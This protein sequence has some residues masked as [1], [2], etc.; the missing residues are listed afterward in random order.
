MNAPHRLLVPLTGAL[1][2]AAAF[3]QSPTKPPPWWGV[4]DENTVSL[5]WSF[6][7]P[8]PN[9]QDIGP[10]TTA[11]VPSWYSPTITRGLRTVNLVHL[12]SFQ[13]HVGVYA[14]QGTGAPLAAA[15]DL[16]VD[17]NAYPDWIKIFQVQYDAYDT[18]GSV[19]A[20]IQESPLFKR[21]IVSEKSEPLANGWNRITIDAQLIPQPDDEDVDWTFLTQALATVAID[22]LYVSSK[23]VKPM[24]DETGDAM[25]LV[26]NR[27]LLPGAVAGTDY[28]GFAFTEGPPPLYQRT[29]WAAR[30]SNQLG[31]Q[32]ALVRFT[33]SLPTLGVATV[34]GLGSLPVTAGQQGTGDLAIENVVTS[35]TATQIVWVVIDERSLAQ[36]NTVRLVGIDANSGVATNILLQ[37]PPTGAIASGQPFGLAFDPSGQLGAGTFWVSATTTANQ[38]VML[39]FSRAG[40]QIEAHAIEPDCSGLAYD[41]TLGNFYGFSHTSRPSPSGP[42]GA[43]GFELSGYDFETTGVRFCGDLT[44][45]TPIGADRGGAAVGLEVYRRRS[46]LT[47]RAPL[48]MSCL[49]TAGGQ[50]YAYELA[51]PFA[52]GWSRLGRCGMNDTGPFRGVPFV[53]S[54]IE[55]TLKGVP[56]S[57]FAMLWL[58]FSNQNS[59]LGPLPIDLGLALGWQESVL[60]ISPDV[61]TALFLPSAPGE[62]TFPIA[63]PNNPLLGYSPVF[64]QWLALDTS[65]TGFF[66]MSQA[67]KTVIYP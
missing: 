54:N 36:P 61:N 1:L 16:K 59:P 25:G 39:E 52:F 18:G 57:L 23:C 33:G 17:N 42:V 10:P 9:P 58:G 64:F 41:D 21:A 28:T 5:Y 60:S 7:V 67:G 44:L 47:T 27:Q 45:P 49:V 40:L 48:T 12:P 2:A 13:N 63:I 15:I 37:F 46:N 50:Q 6:D 26:G 19:A 34:T 20:A 65:V 55:V 4:N 31:V 56:H 24:P 30:R 43:N 3:A 53:G 11:V 22:N 8:S 14:L 35:T 62:F 29:Y 51:G 32:H 38:G 66:A